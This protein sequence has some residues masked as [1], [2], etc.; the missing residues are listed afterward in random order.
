ML[1]K[2]KYKLA[3]L[4]IKKAEKQGKILNLYEVLRNLENYKKEYHIII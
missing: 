3:Y 1:K 2:D 4:I